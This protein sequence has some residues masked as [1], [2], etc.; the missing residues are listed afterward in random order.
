MLAKAIANENAP[1]LQSS[2]LVVEFPSAPCVR[3]EDPL[4]EAS[5]PLVR[6]VADVHKAMR[7]VRDPDPSKMDAR[8][9]RPDR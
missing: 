4:S 5:G 2:E 3:G 7:A 9:L 8:E 1:M 6:T